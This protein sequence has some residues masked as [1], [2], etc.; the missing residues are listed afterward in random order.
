MTPDSETGSLDV[1]FARLAEWINLGVPGIV[2]IRYAG[3]AGRDELLDRL[4]AR[5]AV[6]R[7]P[8]LPPEPAE[9][10]TWLEREIAGERKPRGEAAKP[11]VAVLFSP[12]AGS[13]DLKAAFRVLNLHREEIA[14][15]DAIQLWFVPLS[16]APVLEA[17]AL[18]LRSWF[19]LRLTLTESPEPLARSDWD[20]PVP[21]VPLEELS[22]T[23]ARFRALSEHDPA[24]YSSPLAWALIRLA[25]GYHSR[26]DRRALESATEA[27]DLSRT[28]FLRQRGN[29]MLHAA[30]LGELAG[31]QLANGDPQ[32]ALATAQEA[33]ILYRGLVQSNR[34]A[35]LPD[36]AMS[37]NNLANAQS[38]VGEREAALGTAQEAVALYR[39]L[40]RRNR[41]AF[42]P[43]LAGSLSNLSIRQS[44]IGD[45]E[46]ALSA[47]T[48]AVALYRELTDHNRRAFLPELARSLSNMANLHIK[49]RERQLALETAHEAV[50]LYR[51]VAASGREDF[52]RGLA[53]S[54]NNLAVSQ[55]K[56]GQPA[57]A[58]AAAQEAVELYRK[59][60]SRNRDAFLPGLAV[61]LNTLASCQREAAEPQDGLST[62]RE[63]VAL[64]RE[65]W[66]QRPQR[67]ATDLA[68][69][70]GL[71]GRILADSGEY[72]QSAS[73]FA[74]AVSVLAP[75]L[76]RYSAALEKLARD[77]LQDYKDA[78]V[79]AGIEADPNVLTK[80]DGVPGP[81]AT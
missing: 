20:V 4:S 58:L 57:A 71:V 12:A 3:E 15:C 72:V 40:V 25:R 16:I 39:E 29:L 33:V 55:R 23:V 6:R 5:T 43:N 34:D 51:E 74:D 69:A 21:E 78:A 68:T 37:L 65:L 44:D 73:A 26:H 28:L 14:R 35:V 13:D 79:R 19:Q 62:A 49:I 46:A 50:A 18:D 76:G 77:L 2:W 52:A 47:A 81:L 32:A 31:C 75:L 59:L 11:V 10:A 60:V 38:E 66:G 53:G 1:V 54:L 7:I 64:F 56:A 61:S 41:D 22:A 17:Q 67:F 9:A 27:A 48:E 24:A 36:L 63:A 42:L 30:A 80:V 70:M 8:F 45:R